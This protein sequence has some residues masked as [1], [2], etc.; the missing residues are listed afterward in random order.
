MNLALF[1]CAEPC[2]EPHWAPRVS[3]GDL[4]PSTTTPVPQTTTSTTPRPP[5]QNVSTTGAEVLHPWL[6]CPVAAGMAE[7]PPEQ[8]TG[9]GPSSICFMG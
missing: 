1:G 7:L 6:L 4:P 9:K 2:V 3:A 5:P 8:G